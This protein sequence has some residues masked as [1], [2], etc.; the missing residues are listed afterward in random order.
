MVLRET[1]KEQHFAM[2]D[3]NLKNLTAWSIAYLLM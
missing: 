3:D 1:I 2:L